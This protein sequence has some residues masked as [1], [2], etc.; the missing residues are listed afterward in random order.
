[1]ASLAIGLAQTHSYKQKQ[2]KKLLMRAAPARLAR[3]RLRS[4]APAPSPAGRAAAA[5]PE[6]VD[7]FVAEVV[8]PVRARWRD[9]LAAEPTLRV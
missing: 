7:R 1:M 6:Q 5:A 9:A 3:R 2:T 8:E 4:G